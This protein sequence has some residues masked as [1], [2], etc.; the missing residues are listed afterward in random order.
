MLI[1]GFLDRVRSL[2]LQVRLVDVKYFKNLSIIGE[3]KDTEAFERESQGEAGP[4]GSSS[5]ILSK[6]ALCHDAHQEFLLDE[7]KRLRVN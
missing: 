5:H 7:E 1:D 2:F 6:I 4:S 3:A